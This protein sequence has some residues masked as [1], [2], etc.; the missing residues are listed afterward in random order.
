MRYPLR[1]AENMHDSAIY[2]ADADHR[3]VAH[4]VDP[5]DIEFAQDI[6]TVLNHWIKASNSII[7]AKAA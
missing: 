6:V 4:V 1:I 2:I 7:K 3:V 5:K